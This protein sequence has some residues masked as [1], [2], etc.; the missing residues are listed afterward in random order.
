MYNRYIPQPDGS[1]QKRR[2][3]ENRQA[4][5]PQAQPQQRHNQR[6]QRQPNCPREE[7]TKQDTCP[8]HQEQPCQPAHERKDPPSRQSGSAFG[9]LRQLLPRD[10]DTGDLIV[11]L[12]LL[13]M[14]ADCEDN[15]N[16]AL[17]TL[18]LYLFM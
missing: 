18:A 17:L 4:G 2:M 7:E 1:Y 9:F 16:T 5:V 15:Q 13:L 8:P 10:F 11:V 6:E 3:Q 12:L 14:A